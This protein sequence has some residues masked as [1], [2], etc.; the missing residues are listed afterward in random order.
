VKVYIAAPWVRKQD[1]I[2]AGKKFE[3]AGFTVVSRWFDHEGNPNDSTGAMSPDDDVQHQA[4]EDMNDVKSADYLVVLNLEK[5]E[6]KAVETG[7]ALSYQIPFICVGPRSNI[8][9]IL[10]NGMFES[11]EAAIEFLQVANPAA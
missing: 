11:V 9:Q 10:G 5:S 7:I 8:F 2:K 6:G 1:A 4:I 3:E